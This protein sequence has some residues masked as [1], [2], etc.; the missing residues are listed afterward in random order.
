MGDRMFSAKSIYGLKALLQIAK[1]DSRPSHIQDL[2][3]KIHAPVKYLEQVLAALG[4]VRILNA[5]RG[6][7]G[8]YRMAKNPVDI[9]LLEVVCT[10]EGKDHEGI[11]MGDVTVQDGVDS[12]LRELSHEIAKK[13]ESTTLQDLLDREQSLLKHKSK[14]YY[15]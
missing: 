1:E 11:L 10:L 6:V 12:W 5:K 8:G 9:K 4:K 7:G 14:M 3:K 2:A 15:I 13:L